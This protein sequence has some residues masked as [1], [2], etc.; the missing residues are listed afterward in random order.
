MTPP[1]HLALVVEAPQ[2]SRRAVA[3]IAA[4]LQRQLVRDVAPIWEVYATIDAFVSLEHVPPGYWPILV[5]DNF[6]GV[7]SVGIHLDRNGQ[8]FALVEASP[9]WSLT[10]SH[11]AIEMVVDPWGSRTVPGGSPMAGQGLVDILVEVCDPSGGARWAYTVNGYLVS[12][13]CTPNYYDP[14]GA[15]GVRYSF[16]GALTGPRQV[17]EAATSRGAIRRPASGGSATGSIRAS[18]VSR[19]SGRST[20][21]AGPSV[22]G[23]TS[24]PPWSS[25][26]PGR[27]E[28]I[29]PSGTPTSGAPAPG[30]PHRRAPR[31]FAVAWRTSAS[32]E[33]RAPATADRAWS[34]GPEGVSTV[35]P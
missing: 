35:E 8:P 11:E 34:T 31:R 10:A 20:R 27:R 18:S 15:P 2:V 30:L 23:S 24:G 9:S 19:A 7:E 13:F 16:T 3:E 33:V 25:S 12:D 5:G 4:A 6:P 32:A 14:V 21:T 22:S 26:T 17:V 29:Q 1:I 28:T